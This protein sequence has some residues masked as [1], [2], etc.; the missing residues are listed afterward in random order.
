MKRK[1]LWKKGLVIG[2]LTGISIMAFSGCGTKDEQ[3]ET[4][5][6][7]PEEADSADTVGE[8]ETSGEAENGEPEEEA[9]DRRS[10]EIQTAKIR[11][12]FSG[13]L[14]E[15][16]CA[17][18]LPDMEVETREDFDYAMSDNQFAIADID[19]DGREELIITYSTASMAGMF[20]VA[21]DYNPDT[22]RLKQEY[23]SF[24]ALTYYDNGII[25]AE[26]SHN[27]TMGSD[28]WPYALYQYQEASDTYAQIGY[29][30]TWSKE[31]SDTYIGHADQPF[32]DE[33]DT[34]G[35][36]VLYNIQKGADPSF[37]YID[38]Q[39]NQADYDEWY[40][41]IMGEADEIQI[42]YKPLEY[43]E[44][45]SYTADYLKLLGEIRKET[46]VDDSADIGLLYLEEEY[47]IEQIEQFVSDNYD[48]AI[49]QVYEE[50]DEEQVGIYNGNEV[51]DFQQ[52]DEGTVTYMGEKVEDITVFG[53]Y[54]G[55]DENAALESLKSYG[56]YHYPG[57][58]IEN[59]FITGVGL[60]NRS[61]WLTI[62]DGKVTMVTVHPF[63]AF[64]G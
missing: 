54:P 29:V 31:V 17:L 60:G 38:Y 24:P 19:N 49:E 34:D 64:A 55:M 14:S 35:D 25:K 9:A 51:F 26:A 28:F 32:P 52:V 41:S 33:L 21:Y 53:I 10:Q 16:I 37:E 44:F 8:G 59:C 58:E 43:G 18:R 63:C 40:D 15:L 27:Q 1:D 62:E 3:E 30:D 11:H 7:E 22:D 2:I 12:Y 39:Y 13:V 23:L 47:P 61:L 6:E 36:G 4:V 45:E 50:F 56:F 42:D 48:I 57:A 20:E 5:W 46:A